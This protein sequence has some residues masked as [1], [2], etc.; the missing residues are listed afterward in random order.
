MVPGAGLWGIY[1]FIPEEDKLLLLFILHT[2]CQRAQ[3]EVKGKLG[4]QDRGVNAGSPEFLGH[5]P[6]TGLVCK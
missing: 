3:E 2:Q 4:Q 1:L 6:L 5:C